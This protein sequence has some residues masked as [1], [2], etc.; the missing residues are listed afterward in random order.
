MSA[1]FSWLGD[2]NPS[3][4]DTPTQTDVFVLVN[5]TTV[6]RAE[7]EIDEKGLRFFFKAT[8]NVASVDLLFFTYR[9]FQKY[10]GQVE[11]RHVRVDVSSAYDAMLYGGYLVQYSYDATTREHEIM[12]I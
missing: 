1:F 11:M 6:A 9:E 5:L 4:V 8:Q 12:F 2:D 3:S 7:Y 10:D